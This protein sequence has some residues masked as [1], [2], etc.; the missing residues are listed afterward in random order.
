MP[1]A[2]G[3]ASGPPSNERDIRAAVTKSCCQINASP[4][5]TLPP[6][7]STGNE[8]EPA[9]LGP[10]QTPDMRIAAPE[11]GTRINNTHLWNENIFPTT[12][13]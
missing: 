12:R 3:V 8:A 6:R 2:A 7:P 11:S 9:P 13:T 5:A 1:S 10:L 4:I